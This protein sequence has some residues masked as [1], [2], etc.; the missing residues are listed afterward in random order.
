MKKLKQ[1]VGVAPS[2]KDGQAKL[3]AHLQQQN[4]NSMVICGQVPDIARIYFL[5]HYARS[6]A[7]I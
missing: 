2:N 3:D 4:K 5:A 6:K 7:A 1:R